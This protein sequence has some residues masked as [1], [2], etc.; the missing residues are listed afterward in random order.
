MSIEREKAELGAQTF[1]G[2]CEHFGGDIH[3]HVLLE[4]LFEGLINA[5]T[6]FVFGEQKQEG[7]EVNNS[8]SRRGGGELE[9]ERSNRP[10]SPSHLAEEDRPDY[11]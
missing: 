8:A 5:E 7:N 11:P 1:Q 9:I 3:A 2:F 10:E 4:V 6:L